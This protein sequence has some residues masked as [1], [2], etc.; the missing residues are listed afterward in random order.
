MKADAALAELASDAGSPAP[1]ELSMAHNKYDSSRE[2]QP[3][4]EGF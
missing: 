3:L 2:I 1:P 4:L